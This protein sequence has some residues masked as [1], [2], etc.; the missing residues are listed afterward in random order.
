[1]EESS[2][3]LHRCGC[4]PQEKPCIVVSSDWKTEIDEY[5]GAE[6][7]NKLYWLFRDSWPVLISGTA[8]NATSLIATYRQLFTPKGVTKV[9]ILA[10]LQEP[11]LK[12]K[13]QLADNY[14]RARLGVDYQY[15]R[16]NK[17]QFDR[18]LWRGIWQDIRRLH[19]NCSLIICGFIE[20]DAFIFHVDAT[21]EVVR[22]ENFL[23]IGTGGT[24][25]TSV[26]CYR[27]QNEDMSIDETVYN[28]FEATKYAWKT[29]APGV[30]KVH[31]FSVVRT[32]QK[33]RA[34]EVG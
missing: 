19:L 8:S 18:A 24:V 30:G 22:D 5:V 6:I 21:T 12:H 2:D 4:N 11:A 3:P 17:E 32:I 34:E 33:M 25:A 7:Q 29:K 27:G 15:F 1:V 26:L 23:A 13:E 9:N 28:M 31:A 20:G 16:A 14:V 10:R